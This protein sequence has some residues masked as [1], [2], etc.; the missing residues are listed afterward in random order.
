MRVPHAR[1]AGTSNVFKITARYMDLFDYRRNVCALPAYATLPH[2]TH[3]PRAFYTFPITPPCVTE[4]IMMMYSPLNLQIQ[5]STRL[6]R[7][8]LHV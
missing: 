5:E 8:Y 6:L 4:S 7:Y 3:V 2:S 1:C